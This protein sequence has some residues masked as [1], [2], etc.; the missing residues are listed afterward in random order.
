MAF[1]KEVT[2]EVVGPEDA[3]Y[4]ATKKVNEFYKSMKVERSWR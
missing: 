2:A 1:P 4:L 3:D